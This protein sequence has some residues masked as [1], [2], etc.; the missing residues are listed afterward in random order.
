MSGR[1]AERILQLVEW[2]ADQTVP[3]SLADAASALGSPKSSTL[4]L[5]RLLA[6]AG[7][8]ER[9]DYGRYLLLRCPGA[10]AANGRGRGILL[11]EADAILRKAVQDSGESG[12]IAVF[13]PDQGIQYIAKVL[14]AREIRYDRNIDV[15]RRPHQVS[16]GII[17]LGSLTNTELDAYIA[18]EDAAGRL[19]G[20]PQ[21]LRDAIAKARAAGIQTNLKGV[22]EGA[23]GM[24]APIRNMDGQIVAAINIAGPA[25]RLEDAAA[26]I[27]PILRKAA[28]EISISLGW[29]PSNGVA[30]DTTGA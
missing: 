24:A 13:G 18:A 28:E 11:R 27:E 14:P 20:D 30:K 23:G 12:F 29:Q 8:V 19:A 15:P 17:L 25:P 10:P 4:S 21:Q 5:L 7:Y 16:S 1:G 22:V 3:V 2:L 9:V 26:E 6:D